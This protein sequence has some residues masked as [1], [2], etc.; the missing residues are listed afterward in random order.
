M[1]F[2]FFSGHLVLILILIIILILILILI[3]IVLIVPREFFNKC[4]FIN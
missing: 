2:Q 3:V 4:E 1:D